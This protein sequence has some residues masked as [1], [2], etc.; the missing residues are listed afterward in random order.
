VANYYPGGPDPYLHYGLSRAD[1]SYDIPSA[2]GSASSGPNNPPNSN[3]DKMRFAGDILSFL[4]S[5]RGRLGG[6]L[7]AGVPVAIGAMEQLGADPTNPGGNLSGGLGAAGG[8]ALGMM[9]GG[10]I[11]QALIPI[12]GLGGAI[13]AGIGG[14]LGTGLGGSAGRNAFDAVSGI[15][16]DPVTKEIDANRR[17]YESMA[18]AQTQAGWKA[19]PLQQAAMRAQSENNQREAQL[20]ADL[21]ARQ[22]Y[23]QALFQGAQGVPG[24]Y[25]DPNFTSML[26]AI[27]G[28]GLG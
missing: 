28:R 5:P 16:N 7:L 6:A 18:D 11:G 2:P 20:A 14:A 22:L 4:K 9:A 24:A 17:R 27:A 10:A 25:R 23:A 8:G 19:L 21:Q 3:G 13:G 12:P 1:Q 15:F 26:G